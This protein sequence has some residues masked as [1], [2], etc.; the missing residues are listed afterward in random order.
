MSDDAPAA[1]S[2]YDLLRTLVDRVGWPSEEE[3]RAAHRSIS[4]AERLGILGNLAVDM[5]CDHP[6]DQRSAGQCMVCGRQ[7]ENTT[8]D[9]DRHRQRFG[10]PF[11]QTGRY[12]R[13]GRRN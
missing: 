3:K 6:D 9:G 10:Q 12:Y 13:P 4:E 1:Y 7:L 11:D 5:V 8:G 2:L